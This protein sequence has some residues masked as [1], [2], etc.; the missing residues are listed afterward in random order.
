MEE[1]ISEN[2]KILYPN[3]E[4]YPKFETYD[5]ND[6]VVLSFIAFA[7]KPPMINQDF[8]EFFTI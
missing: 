3:L 7:E 2:L 1:I 4:K 5:L 8:L 6:P